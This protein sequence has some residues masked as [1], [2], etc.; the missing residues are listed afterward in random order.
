MPSKLKSGGTFPY[1]LSDERGEDKP[2]VFMLRV[3]SCLEEAELVE[4]RD[5]YFNRGDSDASESTMLGEMLSIALA[6][7]SIEGQPEDP[8]AFLTS[9]EC[10][11][12]VAGA[13]T[14]AALSADER[15]KFVSHPASGMECSAS[16]VEA[17]ESA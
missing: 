5:R 9:R 12:L 11:Q 13:I 8:R 7:H 6:S 3:L 15:K 10:F 4:S 2:A 16:D 14:G 1:V 17:T